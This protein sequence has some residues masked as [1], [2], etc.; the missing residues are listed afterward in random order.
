MRP[1]EELWALFDEFNS[2]QVRSIYFF[3]IHV[4]FKKKHL[5]L[6]QLEAGG[7]GG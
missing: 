5:S 4:M 7:R 2:T 6:S 3:V 1:V